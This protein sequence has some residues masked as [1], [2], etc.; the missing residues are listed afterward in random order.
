M[1]PWAV[2]E[3]E[4]AVN[5]DAICKCMEIEENKIFTTLAP[6]AAVCEIPVEMH[7]ILSEVSLI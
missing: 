1:K 2:E 5:Y 4:V 6:S 7:L 3:L